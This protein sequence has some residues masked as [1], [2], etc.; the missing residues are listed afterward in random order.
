VV[1]NFHYTH[2]IEEDNIPSSKAHALFS[3]KTEATGFYLQ[4]LLFVMSEY[5]LLLAT[6]QCPVNVDKQT[7]HKQKYLRLIFKA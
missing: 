2:V 7:S 5:F 4:E 3:S 6:V 1:Q